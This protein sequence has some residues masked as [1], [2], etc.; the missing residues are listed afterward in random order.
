MYSNSKELIISQISIIHTHVLL[1]LS[2][3][4]EK[5]DLFYNQFSEYCSVICYDHQGDFKVHED[6]KH[7]EKFKSLGDSEKKLQF[8]SARQIACR[9]L[10]SR[11]YLCQKVYALSIFFVC[12]NSVV[13]LFYVCTLYNLFDS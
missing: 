10:G 8:F 12:F 4:K 5:K 9:L 1:P 7:R 6:K 3:K 2:Q 13:H 11:D